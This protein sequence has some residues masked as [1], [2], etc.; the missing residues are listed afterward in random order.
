MGA[1][2]CTVKQSGQNN[3]PRHPL[4]VSVVL[5]PKNINRANQ[6]ITGF[7]TFSCRGPTFIFAFIFAFV[8]ALVLVLLVLLVPLL[9]LAFF[10]FRRLPHLLFCFCFSFSSF[11]H[12]AVSSR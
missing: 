11:P 5:I 8:F 12:L 10:L 4:F 2:E 1:I 6:T 3:K 9:L 7:L